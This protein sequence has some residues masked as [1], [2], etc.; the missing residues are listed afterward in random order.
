MIA[1]IGATNVQ[2]AYVPLPDDSQQLQ[3]V[4][5]YNQSIRYKVEYKNNTA[6][7][8]YKQK[9]KIALTICIVHSHPSL[10]THHV[11]W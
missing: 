2:M 9:L 4:G 11:L 10:H 1:S 6:L 5:K 8:C 3:K 7:S